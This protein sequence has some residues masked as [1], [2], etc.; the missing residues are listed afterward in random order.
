MIG[1]AETYMAA[2]RRCFHSNL[3]VPASPRLPLKDVEVSESEKNIAG[4]GDGKV[5]REEEDEPPVKK[6]L[7]D[8]DVKE[9]EVTQSQ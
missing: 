2:C 6:A 8:Q 3:S 4:D 1:G 7:F 9:N 5:S